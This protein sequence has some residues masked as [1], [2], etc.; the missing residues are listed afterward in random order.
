M[1]VRIGREGILHDRKEESSKS[2]TPS[3]TGNRAAPYGRIPVYQSFIFNFQERICM[4]NLTTFLALVAFLTMALSA[5]AMAQCPMQGGQ[6]AGGPMMQ[7]APGAAVTPETLLKFN[8]ETKAFQEQLIDKQALLKKEFLKDD[9]DPEALA[10]IKKSMIDI[11][12]EIQKVAKKLGMKNWYCSCPM[13]MGNGCGGGG[14]CGGGMRG[15]GK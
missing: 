15:C 10:T 12:K 2:S 6:K 1:A 11:E 7:C 8:K 3:T 13:S 4:K 9:P 5:G 14:G